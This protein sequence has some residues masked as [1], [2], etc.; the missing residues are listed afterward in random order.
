MISE[1]EHIFLIPLV[2]CSFK[3]AKTQIVSKCLELVYSFCCWVTIV[4]FYILE[5]DLWFKVW[6]EM[7]FFCLVGCFF[8]LLTVS[9]AEH[10]LSSLKHFQIDDVF[11][12]FSHKLKNFMYL[13]GGSGEGRGE[14]NRDIRTER[15]PIHQLVTLMWE[16]KLPRAQRRSP[17]WLQELSDLSRFH[18]LVGC[19]LEQGWSPELELGAELRH[20]DC[21]SNVPRALVHCSLTFFFL[22][23]SCFYSVLMLLVLV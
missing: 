12:P 5:N 11:I 2:L 14:K 22:F 20:L 10:I 19:A 7:T 6:F 23:Y 21:S 3:D 8:T 1:S 4:P 13:S 18:C 15:T 9:F 16:L 17:V